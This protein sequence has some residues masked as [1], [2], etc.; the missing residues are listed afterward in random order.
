MG[1]V[2]I[3]VP[4][5]PM[6]RWVELRIAERL[7]IA[8]NLRFVRLERFL[9]AWLS[10]LGQEVTGANALEG[11]VLRVLLAQRRSERAANPSSTERGSE[12]GPV[13]RWL[14]AGGERDD[15]HDIRCV[16]LSRR[17]ARLYGEYSFSRAPMLV[18]WARGE[19][20]TPPAWQSTERWQRALFL[21]ARALS[22][23]DS[24]AS[25]L[26]S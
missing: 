2:T 12:L 16:E 25:A 15:A 8:A 10:R 3:V 4:N 14:E 26:T 5:R 18:A 19:L 7:G 9:G 22:A 20:A 11:R 1:P 17:L 13:W 23:G 6:E 21:E 24:A